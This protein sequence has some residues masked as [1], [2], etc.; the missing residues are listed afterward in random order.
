MFQRMR[1]RFG[2]ALLL[3]YLAWE[4]LGFFL[5][6]IGRMQM[7][8]E[9]LPSA[10]QFL[11][12]PATRVVVLIG[13]IALIIWAYADSQR[14]SNIERHPKMTCILYIITGAVIG[15]LAGLGVFI[16]RETPSVGIETTKREAKLAETVE[17]PPKPISQEATAD[18]DKLEPRQ[19]ASDSIQKE[20]PAPHVSA[21]G[22]IA[23]G[24]DNL[25]TAIV[26]P[27][28]NPYAPVVTYDFN[29]AKRTTSK[30][31]SK[32]VVEVGEEVGEYGLM[33]ELHDKKDWKTLAEVSEAR[34]KKTPEWLTP[35]VFA[36]V[37]LENMGKR[38]EAIKQLEYVFKKSGGQGE[39]KDAA[40]I[41]RELRKPRD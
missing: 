34:I 33:A 23:I 6:S 5:D 4:A 32:V 30:G 20:P 27:P 35:Y 13:G 15:A 10:L 16:W 11:S 12:H 19:V 9:I 26:N 37:A 3:V 39:Y 18:K 7:L 25:G 31:G 38:E 1:A 29:G 2:A 24:R 22:G 14:D 40:R 8:V 17:E 36:G 21:P 41:L 28:V